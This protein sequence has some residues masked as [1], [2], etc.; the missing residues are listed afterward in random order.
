MAQTWG[1]RVN[2][3]GDEIGPVRV[4]LSL[5]R[6][7]AVII[8][9]GRTEMTVRIPLESWRKLVSTSEEAAKETRDLPVTAPGDFNTSRRAH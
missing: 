2:S 4:S 9:T 8:V 5:N 7:N 1:T 6:Q 3:R